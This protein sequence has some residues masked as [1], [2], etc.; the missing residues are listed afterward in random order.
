MITL[1]LDPELEQTINNTARNLGQSKSEL[2]RRSI[3]EYLAKLQK[4][5]SWESGEELFGRYSS[6]LGNL[7]SDR[8]K[9][10]KNRLTAKRK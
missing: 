1:R 7:S 10:I 8:K 6:N 3:I 2:I 4:P 5:S 9:L